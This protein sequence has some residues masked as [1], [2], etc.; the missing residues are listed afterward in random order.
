MLDIG[1]GLS[2]GVASVGNMGLSMRYGYTALGDTVNLS[3]RLEGLNKEY[4]SHILLS[5]TTYEEVE[6]PLLIFRELDLIRV[7]GK[8][9]PVTL[10]ELMGS[11][12]APE[13]D[14][15]G[16]EDHLELFALGRACYRKRRWQDAQIIFEQ[17]LERWPDD[18][19]AQMYVNRCRE[20][21]V[22]GPEQDWDGVYVMTHK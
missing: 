10:Y 2:T 7:K 1:V 16:L 4:G 6:D 11:R 9:Q 21:N 8:L 3:A 5:E 18:G 12:G 17:I 19:P 13:G 20:Y 14:A 15:P 22:A